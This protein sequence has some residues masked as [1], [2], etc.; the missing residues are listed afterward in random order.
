MRVQ[1]SVAVRSNA[2]SVSS[3][4]RLARGIGDAPMDQF[5]SAGK[6]GTD[7]AHAIA[8]ADTRRGAWSDAPP[9]SMPR[10]RITC[11]TLGC[12]GLGWLPAL[13]ALTAPPDSC[14]ASASAICERALLPVYKNSTR[15][16]VEAGSRAERG[17]GVGARP[18]CDTPALVS[19]SPQRARSRTYP[20]ATGA[21]SA[22]EAAAVSSRHVLSWRSLAQ[23]IHQY[24]L[25]RLLDPTISD[26]DPQ[27]DPQRSGRTTLPPSVS[28][29]PG[30]CATSHTWPSRSRKPPA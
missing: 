11:T 5:G 26:D 12:S 4:L 13:A 28:P 27:P 10:S 16:G 21:P 30:L 25:M 23:T 19:S 15:A 9:R 6:L 1:S 18:G 20:S 8:E 14:S 22:A 3:S 29:N 7:L 2:G 17:S 24:S